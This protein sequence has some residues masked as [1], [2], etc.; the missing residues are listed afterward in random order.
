MTRVTGYQ[1]I[2]SPRGARAKRRY[3]QMT[4]LDGGETKIGKGLEGEETGVED[5]RR[6]E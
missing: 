2:H 3:V 5:S 6:E 4:T 1:N